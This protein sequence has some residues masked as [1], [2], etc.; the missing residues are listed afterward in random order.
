MTFFKKI[1]DLYTNTGGTTLH[2]FAGI[3][4]G[5]KSADDLARNAMRNNK[6]KKRWQATKVL[7]VD[8]ISMISVSKRMT[9]EGSAAKN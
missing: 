8:E 4:L 9:G 5:E 7:I 6:V 2:S 1:V 3:G